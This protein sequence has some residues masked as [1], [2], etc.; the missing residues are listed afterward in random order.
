[1]SDPQSDRSEI[2]AVHQR[3]MKASAGLH[4]DEMRQCFV[5][6]PHLDMWNRNGHAYHGVDEL[7]QL[8]RHLHG[9]VDL[10]TC[11][12][13][14]PPAVHIV[15]DVAWLAFETMEMD[16]R[17]LNGE[18]VRH[19]IMRGT[20]VYRRDDGLGN[21]RWTIWHCHYSNCAPAAEGRPGF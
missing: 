5:Q 13:V 21:P 17:P 2:L 1:M 7:A 15:G 4:I 19:H 16:I 3:W 8:W 12:E 18:P 20:E 11:H 14:T 6:G 9:I 10:E